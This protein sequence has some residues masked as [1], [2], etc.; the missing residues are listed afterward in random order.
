VDLFAPRIKTTLASLRANLPARIAVFNAEAGIQLAVPADDA[1]A[2]SPPRPGLGYVFGG[3]PHIGAGE[4]P[5]IEVSIPDAAVENLSLAHVEGDLS[6]SLVVAVWAG[7]TS[8]E[9]FPTV[10]EKVLGYTRCITEVLLV[11]GA[12]YPSE[13][14]DRVRYAF[15]ANPDRRERDEMETFTFGGFLFFTT[16]GVAARP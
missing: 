5:K 14:V 6:S 7:R 2:L 15:A 9:D 3:L 16:D 10:Y 8:G 12:I 11:P 13:T 1:G 4:Y